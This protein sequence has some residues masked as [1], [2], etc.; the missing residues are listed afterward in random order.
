MAIF[1]KKNTTL[2]ELKAL[3]GGKSGGISNNETMPIAVENS[4]SDSEQKN[5]NALKAMVKR[6][7]IG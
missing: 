4:K 2:S 1:R 7:K 5:A 6:A 3:R